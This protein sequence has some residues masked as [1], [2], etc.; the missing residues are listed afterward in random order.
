MR[1]NSQLH[2][3]K[4]RIKPY[5]HTYILYLMYVCICFLSIK[6]IQVSLLLFMP[7]RKK[8]GDTN[9]KIEGGKGHWIIFHNCE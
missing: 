4:I 2:E 1:K 8:V 7:E 3:N 5:I 6:Y 9:R